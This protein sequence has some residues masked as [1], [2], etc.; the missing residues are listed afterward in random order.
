MS[1]FALV[2]IF[3]YVWGSAT[4]ASRARTLCMFIII[5]IVIIIII[6]IVIIIIIIIFIS[7]LNVWFEG[8]V[9]LIVFWNKNTQKFSYKSLLA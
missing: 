9:W 2:S 7:T 1:S 8:C 5:I 6:I 4:R 3:F